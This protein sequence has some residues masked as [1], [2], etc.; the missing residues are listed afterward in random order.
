MKAH[1]SGFRIFSLVRCNFNYIVLKISDQLAKNLDFFRG[2]KVDK[3]S[4]QALDHAL[5]FTVSSGLIYMR[6]FAI[7]FKKSGTRVCLSM[8]N[9]C[10]Y[11]Q[12]LIVSC[13]T[14][15]MNS[16]IIMPL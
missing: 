14:T 1:S 11:A 3:L 6:P 10:F 8:V 12:I 5:V 4:L 15:E 16:P 2:D 9:V 7:D 13:H